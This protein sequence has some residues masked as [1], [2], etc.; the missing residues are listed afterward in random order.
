MSVCRFSFDIVNVKKLNAALTKATSFLVY[1]YREG[2]GEEEEEGGQLHLV[3]QKS[4]A[5]VTDA[6]LLYKY[7]YAIDRWISVSCLLSP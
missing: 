4:D 3:P 2:Q 6:R 1:L 5:N 7:V